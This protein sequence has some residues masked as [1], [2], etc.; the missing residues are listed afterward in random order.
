MNFNFAFELVCNMMSFFSVIKNFIQ[1]FELYQIF[2][3]IFS[4]ILRV[5]PKWTVLMSQR[6]RSLKWTFRSLS[7][8]EP[9]TFMSNDCP[10]WARRTVHFRT[11]WPSTLNWTRFCAKSCLRLFRSKSYPSNFRFW[12]AKMLRNLNF[13]WFHRFTSFSEPKVDLELVT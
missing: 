4:S 6:G 11:F 12:M 7:S 8:L 5:R 2:R 10:V 9:S 1:K 3:K 13:N